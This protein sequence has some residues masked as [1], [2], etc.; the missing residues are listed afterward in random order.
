MN[1]TINNNTLIN[2]DTLRE[3]IEVLERE[4]ILVISNDKDYIN[5]NKVSTEEL[6]FIVSYDL[7]LS[8]YNSDIGCSIF[9]PATVG[10]TI[11]GELISNIK[12]LA[13]SDLLGC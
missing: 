11:L 13:Y 5:I 2:K 9:I 3:I 10:E 6:G 12:L 7:H 4:T 8:K 1:K